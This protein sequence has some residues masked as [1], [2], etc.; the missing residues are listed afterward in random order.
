M[1]TIAMQTK[2][3]RPSKFSGSLAIPA[4]KSDTQR[5]WIA[6][7]LAHGVSILWGVGFSDDEVAVMEAIQELGARVKRN[8]D[9]SFHVS[10]GLH[11]E[12]GQVV[13]AGESGLGSRLLT[14]V[15]ASFSEPLTIKAEGSL[16]HRPMDFF[17]RYLP[18]FGVQVYATDGRLPITVKGPMCGAQMQVDGCLSSQFI[19]SLLMALPMASSDSLLRVE[20]LQSRPYVDMTLATLSAFGI[21]IIEPTCGSFEMRGN[22]TYKPT[23]YTIEGDWSAAAFWLV[24]GALGSAITLSGLQMESLQAD[25]KLLEFLEKA[26]CKIIHSPIGI[27][28]D[29]SARKSFHVNATHC[30]DLFPALVVLAAGI[31]GVSKIDGAARLEHKESHRGLT[32]QEEFGKLGLQIELDEDTMIIFGTGRLKGGVSVFAH[33]DHRIAMALGIAALLIDSEIHLKGHE[34]VSKSYPQFWDHLESVVI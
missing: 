16:K 32:L 26:N 11:P 30:P 10:G 5:A 29:G 7:A 3:I 23:N 2:V 18:Q 1:K 33:D 14:G 31:N 15:C 12:E 9:G 21:E 13:N 22:Q 25:K 34:V 24:A 20:N 8:D 4:S 28:V 19:S 6:S 17:E 27:R